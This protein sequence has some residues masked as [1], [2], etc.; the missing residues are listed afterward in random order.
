MHDQLFVVTGASG[1]IGR[2][3]SELLLEGHRRVRVVARR[4]AHL[5]TFAERGA[6]ALTGDLDDAAFARRAFAGA[7]AAFT[8]LPPVMA[9][10]DLRADLNR[11]SEAIAFGLREARVPFVVNLSSIG[12]EVPY[13]T[14]P[15]AGLHDHEERL[16]RLDDTQIVHLRPTFFMENHLHAIG[17][18][19]HGGVY[20]STLRGD[21]PLPMIATRDIADEAAR[22]LAG[23]E[24]EGKSTRSLLG[25]RDYTLQQAAQ[26]LGAAIG[27]PELRYVQVADEQAHQAM[28]AQGMPAH[29]TDMML[30]MNRAWNAGKIRPEEPRLPEN[31]TFTTLESWAPHFADV[32]RHHQHPPH[33][34]PGGA[35]DPSQH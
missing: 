11:I 17:A 10:R 24:F 5:R 21:L 2:R 4:E 25:A 32:Y 15:I 29:L 23:L 14:G 22:L 28:V 12:A 35:V 27:K 1:N 26:V 3:L 6:E 13:G 8:M 30:E 7:H 19:L 18:I 34:A 16:D 9:E 20:P 31:T 33:P